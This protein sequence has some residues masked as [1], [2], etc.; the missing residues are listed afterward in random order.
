MVQS[1]IAPATEDF[2]ADA[3]VSTFTSKCI[4]KVTSNQFTLVVELNGAEYIAVTAM[5]L[6]RSQS[7][8]SF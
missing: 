5:K 1:I 8:L 2:N 3:L 6:R 4:D 7:D